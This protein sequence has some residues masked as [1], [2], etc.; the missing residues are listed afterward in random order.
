MTRI[1]FVA[2]ATTLLSTA[3]FSTSGYA[4]DELS[5]ARADALQHC[6]VTAQ[7][8]WSGKYDYERNQ[9]AVY[10]ACMFSHGQP[11]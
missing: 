7:K 11:E 8:R 2:V 10:E 1:F 9:R 3:G 4:A 6:N 5:R